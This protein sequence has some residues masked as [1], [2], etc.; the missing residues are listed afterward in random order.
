MPIA[1]DSVTLYDANGAPANLP[2]EPLSDDDL[3][4]LLEYK[5]FLARHG[6][7]EALYCT[8]CWTK[9]LEDGT[10]AEVKTEGLTV[11]ALIQCRCRVAYGRGGGIH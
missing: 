7:R 11:E 2:H 10:R 9:N 8:R 5:K 1:P 4:L 3:R 6:Y